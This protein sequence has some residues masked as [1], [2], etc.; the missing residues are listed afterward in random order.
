MSVAFLQGSIIL[1]N[2]FHSAHTVFHML[3]RKLFA[4]RGWLFLFAATPP[5]LLSQTTVRSV[6]FSGNEFFSQQ[7]LADIVLLKTG[8][9]YNHAAVQHATEELLGIYQREGFYACAVDSIRNVFSNDSQTVDITFYLHEGNRTLLADISFVGNSHVHTNALLSL[10]ETPIAAPLYSAQLEKDISAILRLYANKG[11]PFATIRSD[12]IIADSL[13]LHVCLIV[14]EGPTVLLSEVQIEGNSRTSSVVLE[15]EVRI[16]NNELFNQEKLERIRRRLERLQLFASV[17][18]PQLYILPGFANDSLRGGLLISVKEGSPNSFDG[19]VGYVPPTLPNTQGYITG[20]VFVAF[21][22]LFGTARKAMV[23]WKR[24]NKTTQEL[25]LQYKEPWLFGIPLNI[26]GTFYQRKQDSSYVKNRFTF[27]GDFSISDELSLG[28]SIASE[29]VYPS[30]HSQQFSVF[31]SNTLFFGAEILYDTRDNLRNPASGVR[32]ATAVQQGTKRITGPERFLSLAQEKNFS[33]QKYSLDAEAF[34]TTFLR[35]V[36]MLGIHGRHISSSQLEVSD[37]YQFGGTTTLRGYRENQFFAS[38]IAWVN[39][40]YRFL[41]G[42]ASSLYGFIDGGY[43]SRPS[44]AMKGITAQEKSLYG[45]GVGARVE[46]G[47]GV[48]N[49]SFALGEGDSFSD[50]KIH[51]GIVNDF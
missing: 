30:A 17:S 29:S 10:M 26:G 11:F 46:T 38:N 41:T 33:I 31:E 5:M 12:S 50:G 49:I 8:G 7:A 37:L 43:F 51:V 23:K 6:Q 25:E 4:L 36:F 3:K 44:D 45:Y 16:G 15:R 2:F 24:E 48:M 22:N 40:E 39:V 1:L 42:R 28:G 13:G 9:S 18:E 14:D 19:I 35:Q 32:Y 20:D 21:R 27:T 47:L 34:F